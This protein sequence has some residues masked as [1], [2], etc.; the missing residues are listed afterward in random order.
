MFNYLQSLINVRRLLSDPEHW[1]RHYGAR[2][3]FG[4]PVNAEDPAAR[5]WC[6]IGAGYVYNVPFTILDAAAVREGYDSAIAF[7]DD[8]LVDHAR[9]LD[10]LDNLIGTSI[11]N[12][13]L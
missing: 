5:C 10:F 9:V 4:Q 2:D 13:I 12:A 7:N 1:T 8:P 3:Q 11:C 6:L